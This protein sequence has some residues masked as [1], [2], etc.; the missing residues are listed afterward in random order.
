MVIATG[1]ARTSRR[2]IEASSNSI[3]SNNYNEKNSDNHLLLALPIYFEIN[4][5]LATILLVKGGILNR[6][7]TFVNSPFSEK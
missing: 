3:N 1:P 7:C 4:S 2:N 5:N 6:S